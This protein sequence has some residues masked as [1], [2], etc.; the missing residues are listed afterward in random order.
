MTYKTLILDFDG[1][2][3]DTK[4]SIL[5]SMKFVAKQLGTSYNEQAIIRCIGLPLKTTFEQALK[6]NESLIPEATSIYRNYYNEIVS[7]TI[8]LFDGVKET[9][10]D[11]HSNGIHLTVASSKGKT[12]LTYILKKHG[13]H[14]LFSFIGGEEDVNQKKPNPEIVQLIMQ[15][16]DHRPDQYLVVGDTVYDIVMGQSAGVPT[17]GVTYGNNTSSQLKE[18]G[19]TYLIDHFDQLRAIVYR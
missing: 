12:A 8:T 3:A 1:T 6:V 18:L 2:L 17:C 13:I 16:S 10:Q 7:D 11:F 9:L 5:Q 4:A 19:P 15:K 14:D